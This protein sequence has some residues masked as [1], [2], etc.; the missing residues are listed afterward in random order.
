MARQFIDRFGHL[1][2]SARRRVVAKTASYTVTIADNGTIFTNEG[3]GALVTFTLPDV[4]AAKGCHYKFFAADND[5]IKVASAV[6]DILVVFNDAAA[7]SVAL[8]T[9]GD[10]IGGCFEVTST[11][12]LWL[13][14][15]H[16][17]DSGV[18]GAQTVTIAT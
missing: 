8:S 14:E 13:V 3:A 4:A 10:V 1:F 7:D 5:G 16:L 9:S 17:Y 15:A 11:G 6:G 12:S 2:R 18:A